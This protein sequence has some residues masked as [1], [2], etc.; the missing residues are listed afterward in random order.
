[1][2]TMPLT[3]TA[4]GDDDV[5]GVFQLLNPM[6]RAMNEVIPFG[7][8]FNPP[9][10]PSIATVAANA[11]ANLL[12]EKEIKELLHSFVKVMTKAIDE[13]SPYNSNH[14]HN[15]ADFCG[16]FADYLASRFPDRDHKFH[17]G[18]NRR[19]QLV[20]SAF[21][22]D[23]GKIITPLGIMDKADR[24]AEQFEVVRFKFDIKK[25]Q[26]E[27]EYLRKEITEE[28]YTGRITEVNDALAL[29]ENVNPAG[30]LPD[31]K[32]ERI[33]KLRAIK[34]TDSTGEIVPVL[35]ESNMLSLTVRKGT[36]TEE[37][38][39]VMQ[40]HVS[41]TGRLL[42]N[43]VFNKNYKDVADWAAGHHEFLDGTGYPRGLKGSEVSVEMCILTIMDIYDALTAS[44][45]PY[46]RGM[47]VEKALSI[48][49]EMVSEGKLDKELTELFKES[50][51][52]RKEV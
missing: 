8:I 1:M 10:L 32:I 42:E 11:L 2:L 5:I 14:T 33:N 47:P 23:I 52:W 44:D 28:E 37:E 17:F 43:M 25:Y 29:I 45:R 9:V 20:M 16:R 35:T 13:R 19:E 15:V 36:L 34:Y 41:V 18:V 30:F 50:E 6:D 51:V 3:A 48:L 27:A 22:H 31:D 40:G 49:S 39:N 26:V 38:R 21:L 4:G 24:L 12:H 7:D 46:K